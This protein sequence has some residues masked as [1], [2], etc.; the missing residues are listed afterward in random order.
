M[1]IAIP[2]VGGELSPHFGHCE[3]FAFVDVDLE[4]KTVLN[5]STVPAPPH[6][7]G[8][9]PRWLVEQ[10][11]N[12][13]IAGGIGSRARDMLEAATVEVAAGAGSAP[14]DAVVRAW[15][16]GTL[17]LSEAGCDH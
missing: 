7:P 4:N 6:Q 8:L 5:S 3:E 15:L 2:L 10:G 12:L 14:P 13:L 9:L 1:R 11:V 16:D 17:D